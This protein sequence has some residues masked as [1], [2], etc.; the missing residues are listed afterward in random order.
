MQAAIKDRYIWYFRLSEPEF[1]TPGPPQFKVKS[2][3]LRALFDGH[4]VED[5]V[6]NRGVTMVD[7]VQSNREPQPRQ[8]YPESIGAR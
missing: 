7:I 6:K 4:L 3:L 8:T 5:S 1:P 2:K